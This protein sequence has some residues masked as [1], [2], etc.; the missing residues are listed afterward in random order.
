MG[1]IV[2]P[3]LS[4]DRYDDLEEGAAMMERHLSDLAVLAPIRDEEGNWEGSDE[5]RSDGETEPASPSGTGDLL[6]PVR[7][8]WQHSASMPPSFRSD[9]KLTGRDLRTRFDGCDDDEGGELSSDG[10][11]RLAATLGSLASSKSRRKV[12]FTERASRSKAPQKGSSRDCLVKKKATDQETLLKLVADEPLPS[13]YCARAL[14]TCWVSPAVERL[15]PGAVDR[16]DVLRKPTK[17]AYQLKMETPPVRSA[18]SPALRASHQLED[19]GDAQA[20]A[21]DNAASRL[22]TKTN[23]S[24]RLGTKS[25]ESELQVSSDGYLPRVGKRQSTATVDAKQLAA[26]LTGSAGSGS[27]QQQNKAGGTNANSVSLVLHPPKNLSGDQIH[28]RLEDQAKG[29]RK[30][31]YAQYM[32]EFDI[33]TGKKKEKVQSNQLRRDEEACLQKM[34]RLIGGEPQRLTFP[35]SS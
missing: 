35:R 8:A 2:P 17:Y 1:N 7:P 11:P 16:A 13:E 9:S 23:A 30:H 29:F 15:C 32:K 20:R 34:S 10:S 25:Q 21:D 4:V 31:T 28:Q 12:S 27:T 26:L 33:L 18:S 6:S 5:Q 24:S 19:A 14:N 22:I 3:E